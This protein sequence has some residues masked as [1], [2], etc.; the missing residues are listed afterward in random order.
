MLAGYFKPNIIVPAGF[1]F[2]AA[3]RPV[4]EHEVAHAARGD[5]YYAARESLCDTR[6][7]IITGAPETLA[8]ALVDTAVEANM[9]RSPELAA[10]AHG[11]DLKARVRRLMSP[12]GAVERSPMATLTFILPVMIGIAVVTTPGLG[13]ADPSS[14]GNAERCWS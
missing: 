10:A 12:T 7:A 1:S 3:A 13:A 5:S 11:T 6:A 14:G 2:G 8:Q 4:L 9:R